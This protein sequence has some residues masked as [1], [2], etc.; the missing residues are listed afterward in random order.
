MADWL[1]DV[2]EPAEFPQA[3]LRFRNDRAAA[4][5]GLA[6]LSDK[7]W[8]RHFARF[9]PLEGNL[10]APLALR[11]HGHQFRVYNPEIGDGR[12]FLFAQLR[13]GAGR[14]LDLGTKGSGLTPYSRTADGRLTM[15]G[16]V[17][18]VLATEMLEALGVHTSRTF[19]VVETGEELIRSDE[20][21]PARSAVLVR[22]SHSHLRI[23]T[24]QR[25][26]A[27]HEHEHLSSLVAYCLA[28][29]P[30]PPP[31]ADAP[32]RDEPA[33]RLMHQA[34]ERLADLAASYMAAGFVHGVLNSDN[35]NITGESFDYGPWRWLP[36]WEPGFTA[37]Y[38]DHAGLYAFG[39]QAEAIQWNLGQLGA[40]LRPLAEAEPLIA[41]FERFAPLYQARLIERFC[42]RLGVAPA[43]GEADGALVGAAER[44]MREAGIGPD[45][46]FFRH[47]GGRGAEGALA[48]ALAGRDEVPLDHNYWA[49]GEPC[50]MLIDEV[51]AIWARIAEHDDWQP[52]YDKVAAV[53]RMGEALGSPPEPAGHVAHE[54][55]QVE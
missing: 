51:E 15:K 42:W 20:P 10:E 55:E 52:L 18:E 32:G 25:L 11:Y 33:V 1:A 30:G 53:R 27:L 35:M 23:G 54:K 6:H 48:E 26:A 46:F 29:Y 31:P 16:A 8:V 22:L 39:R 17:R 4:E 12:G 49:D 3:M 24:F 34:V 40:S 38:F 14:L 9:E 36:T 50:S 45:A 19:S 41:A 44:A 2:V 13:D 43:G 5:V 28:H 37:A 47:R 21:S 7:D